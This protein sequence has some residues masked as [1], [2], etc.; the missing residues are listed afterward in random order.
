MKIGIF[1]DTYKPATDGVVVSIGLFQEELERLGHQ[2]YIFAPSYSNAEPDPPRVIRYRNLSLP[3]YP[4]YKM[5]LPSARG[6]SASDFRDLGLDLVHI[7]TPAGM[8][9]YGIYLARKYRI[10]AIF[11]YHTYFD[12]YLHYLPGPKFFYKKLVRGITRWYSNLFPLILTP[13][14]PI[15]DALESYGI[16]SRIETQLTGLNFSRTKPSGVDVR[17][18]LGVRKG[19]LLLCTAGRLGKEKNFSLVLKAFKIA[20]DRLGKGKLVLMGDGP[21]GNRLKAMAV[22]LGLKDQA[23]FAGMVPRQKVIDTFAASDLFVFGSVSE[24]QGMVLLEALSQGTPAVAVD[25]LGPGDLLRGDR[26]G[27]LC[28]ATPED[29]AE[30]IVRM[31]KDRKLMARKKVEA[32]KRALEVSSRAMTRRLVGFYREAIQLSGSRTV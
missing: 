8:G 9:F 3:T 16:K 11:T 22:A 25:A 20:R 7:Q 18:A 5:V 12:L 15:K 31:V 30:K 21:E 14:Q 6:F 1:T 13:S 17:K 10:P 24:T 4:E 32:R 19:E 28:Q 29:M 23:L 2:V 26:G 27:L